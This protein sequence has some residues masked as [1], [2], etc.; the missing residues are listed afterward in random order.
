MT[1]CWYEICAANWFEI[2]INFTCIVATSQRFDWLINNIVDVEQ[3]E[4]DDKNV[5]FEKFETLFAST[6][7][8]VFDSWLIEMKIRV[9]NSNWSQK[10][11][12]WTTWIFCWISDEADLWL[13][14]W[15]NF[16]KIFLFVCD[17]SSFQIFNLLSSKYDFFAVSRRSRRVYFSKTRR[18]C[19]W[20]YEKK[21]Y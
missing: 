12:F 20:M 6:I 8:D 14:N 5:E 19:F 17:S 21:C 4:I 13:I 11:L 15:Q 1:I 3:N 10:F 9:S 18:W 7:C 2:M 16:E